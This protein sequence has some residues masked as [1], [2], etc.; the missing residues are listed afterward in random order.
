MKTRLP[1][2]ILGATGMVGQR[3]IQL[4]EN[5]PW[6][7]VAWLA[8]SDRSSGK[9][10]GEAAKWRLD[11]PLPGRIAQ[12]TVSPAGPA[13]AP[14]I[15]FASVDAPIARELEPLFAAA[16]CAV[17]SNSSAFRM[18]PNVPLV[19]PEVNADH[20]HLIEEQSWRKDSGGYIVTN[21]NC[22]AMGPVLALKPLVDRFG[23]EQIF[24]TSMQAVSGAGYPGVASMDILDNVVPYIA[25]EEEK[26]EAETL[27]LL[28]VLHGHSVIPLPAR[29][30]ASCNRV[31][32]VDGHTVSVSIKLI[33]P[34]AREDILAAWAEFRPLAGQSLPTAPS[35][36]VEWA[37]EAD[38]PQPRL[39]RN[40]GNG[41]AVTVGRLR[42]CNL[43]DWKFTVLSHNTV[44]GAAGAAILNAELLASLGKLEPLTVAA[45]GV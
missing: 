19:L 31:P 25:G 8:A 14:K 11:T 45:A 12:M 18:A 16:G 9:S 22:T 33:R 20:L 15:I 17:V 34:A 4:L 39:D 10:Y 40:R 23:V 27:K 6:F 36:P 7:E 5:H 32:V 35:Q 2:G 3:F 44:R 13:G 30:S 24:A 42:P 38:R 28:G 37:P 21:S 1:I 41:M 43:L 29:V 26:F